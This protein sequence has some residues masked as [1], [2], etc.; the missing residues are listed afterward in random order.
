MNRITKRILACLFVFSAK[1]LLIYNEEG[2][3]LLCFIAFIAFSGIYMGDSVQEFF[4]ERRQIIKKELERSLE[5]E[6]QYINKYSNEL[7][8]YQEVKNWVTKMSPFY[9]LYIENLVISKE[10]AFKYICSQQ[11]TSKL[12]NLTYSQKLSQEELPFIILSNFRES[13]LESFKLSKKQLRIKLIR[14][15]LQKLAS[16]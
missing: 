5:L 12:K 7:D 3:V 6:I 14:E 16:K 10:K 2:L 15:S 8:S 11:L 13:V 4:S 1:Q 9:K